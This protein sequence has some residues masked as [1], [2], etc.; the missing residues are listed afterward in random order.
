MSTTEPAT[1]H[2]FAEHHSIA[3]CEC[4]ATFEGE[5]EGEALAQWYEHAQEAEA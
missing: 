5:H 2:D 4:G 3:T 1:G